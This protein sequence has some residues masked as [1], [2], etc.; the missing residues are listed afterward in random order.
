L[1][2][3]RAF[4]GHPLADLLLV[5]DAALGAAVADLG[6]GGHVDGVVELSVPAPGEPVNLPVAGGDLDRRGAVIGGEVVAAR[7][8][9]DVTYVA[10]YGAGDDRP[11]P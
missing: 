8:A 1:R 7:E 5:V 11:T 4:A 10:E 9:V 3:Q 6:D 2:A